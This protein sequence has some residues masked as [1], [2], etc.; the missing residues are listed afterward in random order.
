MLKLTYTK[1]FFECLQEQHI[2]HVLG[3]K[4]SLQEGQV[5]FTRWKLSQVK[6]HM[7]KR[8]DTK[9]F[10]ACQPEQIIALSE[11]SE[12]T[13]PLSSSMVEIMLLR[14]LIVAVASKKIVLQSADLTH[15]TEPCCF[16]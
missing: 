8:T 11:C 15:F 13:M 7:L 10:F 9:P 3:T 2:V 6:M 1:P 12:K 5:N 14:C 16:Q 4:R